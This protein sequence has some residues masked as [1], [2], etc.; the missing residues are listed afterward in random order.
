MDQGVGET[1]RRLVPAGG[2][3]QVA[4]AVDADARA[5]YEDRVADGRAPF[6]PVCEIGV[7]PPFVD[8]QRQVLAGEGDQLGA[9]AP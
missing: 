2:V 7:G 8:D 9:I 3:D 6:G 5:P 4:A 1:L